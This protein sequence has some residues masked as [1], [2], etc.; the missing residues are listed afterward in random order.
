MLE[1]VDRGWRVA[2]TG[3][4]FSTFGLGGLALRMVAFPLLRLGVWQR[5]RRTEL[6][7]DMIRW[8]FRAFVQLMCRVGVMRL[9]VRNA[10]RLD[11]RGL[12]VLANHPTLVDVVILM[13]LVRNADCVVKASLIR[14]PFMR[15]PVQT[16]G[17]ICN[18]NGPGIVDDAIGSLRSG[19]NLIIFPEGTRTRPGQPMRLQ[20]GAANVAVRGALDIT[21]VVIRCDIPWLTK[22]AA[23]WRV[24]LRRANVVVE[25]QPDLAVRPFLDDP[26]ALAARRLTDHLAD[27]FAKELARVH[28]AA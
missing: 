19:S 26:P 3:F 16:A 7:R 23:W 12:L 15:G 14:N 13:S 10:E 11:R 1:H 27:H 25:V 21:P 5:R 22:G 8:S 18:D 28:A 4:C 17:F 9:E 20:R 24:P 2:A 6:A